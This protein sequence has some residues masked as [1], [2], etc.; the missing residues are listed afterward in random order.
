MQASLSRNTADFTDF[1]T[2]VYF[3]SILRH[4]LTRSN[5]DFPAEIKTVLENTSLGDSDAVNAAI[6]L[7]KTEL[8]NK[9]VDLAAMRAQIV[10]LRTQESKITSLQ[11]AD[12]Y[13]QEVDYIQTKAA[14]LEEQANALQDKI[15]S[16][17]AV[18]TQA[19]TMANTK[20]AQTII[21]FAFLLSLLS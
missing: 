1:N 9:A 11:N 5:S 12:L 20:Q 3:W 13:Q 7:R 18:A 8:L 4:A 2:T 6:A 14:E 15:T 17:S 19:Q 10:D 21:P 16:A